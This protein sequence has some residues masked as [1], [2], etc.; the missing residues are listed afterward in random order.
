MAAITH[1][2]MQLLSF[3]TDGH[4][5]HFRLP[6]RVLATPRLSTRATGSEYQDTVPVGVPHLHPGMSWRVRYGPYG[7]RTVRDTDGVAGWSYGVHANPTLT[8]VLV[9]T[10]GKI[11]AGADLTLAVAHNVGHS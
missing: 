5:T 7:A 3:G 11:K 1:C 10:L 6:R 8:R 2:D 9:P 4:S